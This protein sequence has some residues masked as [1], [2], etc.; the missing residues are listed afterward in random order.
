MSGLALLGLSVL[1]GLGAG[2]P[3]CLSRQLRM[4]G[5]YVLG[6][7]FPL[8]AAEDTGLGPRTQ[9][10]TTVC[11]RFSSLGLLWALAMKMAVEEINRGAALLPG[12]RLG[13]DIFDTCSEPVV[14]MQPS[15]A[16]MAEAG[17]CEI[18]A[19]CDYSRYQP[20]VLAVVGPHSTELALVTGKFFGFF[21][22]PQVS[23]GAS[24]DQLSNRKAFPSFF[25]TVPSDRVQVTAVVELLHALQWNWVAAVGSD[26]EY[27]RQGLSLF[28]SLANARGICIAHEGLVPAAGAHGLQL[29]AVQG[30]LHQVS[31][32][33][34]QV[35]VLFSS[36]RAARA[37]FSF[38]IRLGLAPKVWVASEAWLTS[39]QVLS[40]PGLAQ[41]GTVLG[42]LQRGAPLPDFPS[43]VQARLA[44][45]ADPAFCA[46]PD[47]GQ[48]DLEGHMAGPRCPQCDRISL[49]DVS[50]GLRHHRAFAAYA[51]VYSVA[52]ALHNTLLCD[53]L[54]CP[55][56]APVQPWQLLE[57]MYNMSFRVRGLPLR[58][59]A[60]GNVDTGYDLKLWVWRDPEPELRTVG[61]FDGRL[62][63]QLPQM[64]WH[65]PG[66]AVS[67]RPCPHR[68]AALQQ[69]LPHLGG[70]GGGGGRPQA[71]GVHPAQRDLSPRTLLQRPVSQCSR[72]C[73][74][75][76]V[77]RVKGFHSCCYDCVDCKAGSYQRSPGGR[78]LCGGGAA[79]QLG[80]LAARAPAGAAGLA[81][82][83]AG[84]AGGGGA[85]HLVPGGLPAGGGDGLAGAAHG[86]AGALPGALLGG[87]RPGARRPRRAG[88]TLLPG[89]LPGA[90]PARPPRRCPQ[91]RLRHAGLLHHLGLLCAPL[92]QRARGLPARR[93]DGH[94]PPL[95][96]GHPGHLP[97]AQVLPAAAA[98]GGQPPR[99][100]PGRGSWQCQWA[101]WQQGWSP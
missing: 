9:P 12:L 89:H 41:V 31:Q 32:S 20:R 29:G 23:Y 71:L 83:A 4:Q 86:G 88:L 7:L 50:A 92:R 16:F 47:A 17:S 58:F 25:R 62:Q 56:R 48:P 98:A 34:V 93:T 22:M 85:V 6:G 30:L 66:N 46:S 43:Y 65:T 26:D 59:D 53:A 64:R 80:R 10:N 96:P 15:L 39:A 69:G 52:Q 28:S 27:G 82:G 78:D 8:G 44:L 94:Q 51:A 2:A 87:I 24:A 38:S 18:A 3:L 54:G 33:R 57:N 79:A 35:V 11:T 84:R 70:A 36:A 67:A 49:E 97:P 40:L 99:V 19:Y 5:D 61:G 90:P 42:F 45:A 68:R 13:H 77:R 60:N 95:R 91:P 101:G 55:P 100:L 76:Q 81:G 14:A 75:G 1:L 37:L 63:L 74:E 21:L 73:Q 72:Q